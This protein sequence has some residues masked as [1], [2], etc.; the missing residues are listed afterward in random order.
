M[1]L[2]VEAQMATDRA[3]VTARSARLRLAGHGDTNVSAIRS[4]KEMV[5]VWAL[6]L[7]KGGWLEQAIHRTGLE[8]DN[9]GAALEVEVHPA[10]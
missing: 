8:H 5:E 3:G 6:S 7:Q 4:L 2:V 10:A 9:D 1:R